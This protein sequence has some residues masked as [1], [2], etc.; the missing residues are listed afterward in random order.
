M[1]DGLV[2]PPAIPPVFVPAN[3]PPAVEAKSVEAWEVLCVLSA[4]VIADVAL[5]R[6]GG[7]TGWAVV[8]V[9]IPVLLYAG[10]P[11]RQ[12]LRSTWLIGI[13]LLTLSTRLVWL[14]STLTVWC[15]AGLTCVFAL[16]LA[17]R[18]V[19]LLESFGF[20]CCVIPSG[21]LGL[22]PYWNHFQR[23]ATS[24]SPKWLNVLLPAGALAVFGMLFIGANPH[25]VDW[26]SAN[27]TKW[28]RTMENWLIHTSP[29]EIV[30]LI[31]AVIV[32]VG[33]LRPIAAI[34]QLADNC[35]PQQTK[36][37]K[38]SFFY[39]PCRNTMVTVAIL[40]AVYLVFEFQTLWFREFPAG[41]HY[42]GY[43][44]QGAAWLTV[45]LVVAT[46][47]LSLIFRGDLLSDPRLG[48]LKM[49]AWIWSLENL[50]LGLAVFNR[51]FIYI[52]FNGMTRMRVIGLFGI[53]AV[54]VGFAIVVTKIIR[55]R[56]F[57]WLLR[58]HLVT[59]AAAF[60]LY[61][62]TPVD[63][64]TTGYNVRRIM[65]GD[66]APA[67]QISVHPIDSQGLM[68]L[69][70]LVDHQ[71]RTIRDGIRA[72]LAEA[73]LRAERKATRANRAGWSEYQISDQWVLSGF[74]KHH[75]Q[76]RDHYR[77]DAKRKTDY[78]RFADFVYQWY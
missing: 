36:E 32:F 74:R 43:A 55:N 28:I 48:Q 50:I 68:R 17:G 9:T 35:P 72:V 71:N 63:W 27:L 11:T 67:V 66:L 60:Y 42:S 77:D 56:S 34:T 41:F 78:Q 45:A 47:M 15:G 40:F 59:L 62:L 29:A 37:G 1:N 39:A 30:F 3:A 12:P 20:A 10:S 75:Q 21:L 6:G 73:H 18:T 70:P 14:G 58:A 52:H 54:I 38:P 26:V 51:M 25:L 57:L 7:F 61:S 19:H 4:I 33:L 8:L 69:R 16:G 53:S 76:W 65:A 13:A 2:T 23:R 49:L 44:H 46:G 31:S 22:V 64:F 24:V 5:F